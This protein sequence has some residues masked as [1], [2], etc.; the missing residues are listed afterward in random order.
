MAPLDTGIARRPDSPAA[1]PA[2]PA[3]TIR[4]RAFQVAAEQ[5]MSGDD[6]VCLI[7]RPFLV[8][9]HA[10]LAPPHSA[11]SCP[12]CC[13]RWRPPP[14][15]AAGGNGARA[16]RWS[17]ASPGAPRRPSWPASANW[18][19]SAISRP[20]CTPPGAALPPE[21]Q[22]RIDALPIS[23]Q[24]DEMRRPNSA[25]CARTPRTRRPTPGQQAQRDAR[26]R[27][28]PR[29]R[30]G[31]PRGLARVV[32]AQPAAGADDLVLDEPLPSTPQGR[33]GPPSAA[34]KTAPS[35][36]TRSA[37]F[38]TCWPRPSAR[39]PCCCTWTMRRTRPADQ[40]E[41]CARADGAAHAGRERRLYADGRAGAGAHPHRP[42]HR[43]ARRA[44]PLRPELRAGGAG[45][46]VPVQSGAPRLRRQAVPGPPHRRRRPGRSRP[47]R[48][49]AGAPSGHRPF[50]Q[51]QAGG[52]FPGRRA[53][54]PALVD[55]MARTFLAQ[56]RRHRRRAADA[57]RLAR[58]R[59]RWTPASSRT[60]C[61]MCIRRCGWP[62]PACRPSSIPGPR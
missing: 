29:R 26:D 50:H 24:S 14:W 27:P 19:R 34:M 16:T 35:G 52:L 61:T 59:A 60:R 54:P 62:M 10:H 20:N 32:L 42:G 12:S 51:R 5:G 15:P 13:C 49:S 57:V 38:A 21:V 3:T 31:R 1:R 40:R 43:P 30:H 18:G 11:V 41:L 6:R 48:G 53:P 55:R 8:S 46:A 47:G 45:R 58:I 39:R 25:G 44:A 33:R 9:V 7:A 17:T 4:F 56:R 22:R 2:G 23:R 28:R 37:E 36:R